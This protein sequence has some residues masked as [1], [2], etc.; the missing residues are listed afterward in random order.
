[1]RRNSFTPVVF[2]VS[3]NCNEPRNNTRFK[4]AVLL[5]FYELQ[6]KSFF[7]RICCINRDKDVF[8]FARITSVALCRM[9]GLQSRISSG[10]VGVLMCAIACAL[11]RCACVQFS[12]IYLYILRSIV[13]FLA[14]AC[15]SCRQCQGLDFYKF[16]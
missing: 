6:R 3:V 2:K 14:D 1:M 10:C 11:C 13:K 15:I 7:V 8:I 9:H 16:L 12:S 4:G 5:I